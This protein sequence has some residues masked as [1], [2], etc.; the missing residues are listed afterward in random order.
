MPRLLPAVCAL[1]AAFSLF[2][3]PACSQN[4][5]ERASV[6]PDG[7]DAL[8]ENDGAAAIAAFRECLQSQRYEWPV[9]A[10]LR[11]RLASAHLAENEGREAL[12]AFNQI[13]ALVEDQGGDIDNPL[14]RRNRAV[15][16]LQ[17]DRP[18]DAIADLRIAAASEPDDAFTWVL[19]GSAYMELDQHAEAVE[20]F[21]AAVRIEPD[22]A[23]GWIGRSAG[24]VE[25]GMTARAVDDGREAVAIAPES[26]DALN[27]LCWALVKDERAAQGLE[28]CEAAVEADPESGAI[29][30]SLAAA[31]EQVGETRRARELYARAYELDPDSD[32]IAEDYERTRR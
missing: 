16:Y 24:F 17:L 26:A 10:E 28:I 3:A 18:R 19:L 22:F 15:A 21:D 29:V 9:E 31:L 7:Y 2:S 5:Q 12:I 8:S 13:F 25:L 4:P 11:L 20:A 6:C 30:H 1:G 32:T 27:A 14:L 23:S